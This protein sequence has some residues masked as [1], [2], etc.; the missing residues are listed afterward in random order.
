MAAALRRTYNVRMDSAGGRR[1]GGAGVRRASSVRVAL[2]V[3]LAVFLGVSGG[4]VAAPLQP[5]RFRVAYEVPQDVG[6]FALYRELRAAH[7]L[8]DVRR[9]LAFVRLPRT[10]RL[11][12]VECDG[13]ANAY[14]DP[15]ALS[16]SVC[17]EYV[18]DLRRLAAGPGR[19]PGVT[20]QGALHGKLL[21]IFLHEAGHALVDLLHIPVFGNQ[22]EAADVF[23]NVVLLHV[24]ERAV[25]E[26]M[27][28]IAWMYAQ[29]ARDDDSVPRNLADGHPLA[30]QRYYNCL[31]LAYGARPQLFADVVRHDELPASRA[32]TC[33]DE[34]R[35]ADYA[36]RKLMGPYLDGVQRDRALAH[37]EWGDGTRA[38]SRTRSASAAGRSGP[39]GSSPKGSR[40]PVDPR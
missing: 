14:Y 31:C 40:A 9:V 26:T 3:G 8:E 32:E 20:P 30:G 36:V 19:P 13:D 7:V 17:Y 25:R 21:E 10:L 1:H 16:V 33:G 35:R 23:A 2:A 28:G 5:D 18:D 39:K 38:T 12:F 15:D 4:A 37:L 6:H 34:Y 27:L 22:E 24:R 11:A 29:E